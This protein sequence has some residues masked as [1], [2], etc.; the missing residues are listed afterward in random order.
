LLD[1]EKNGVNEKKRNIYYTASQPPP[2]G[3]TP[4]VNEKEDAEW[5]KSRPNLL[6]TL[7][8]YGLAGLLD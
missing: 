5:D 4:E 7:Y 3:P 2:G 1:K 8:K 6:G